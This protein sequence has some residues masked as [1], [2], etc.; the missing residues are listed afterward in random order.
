MYL[1]TKEN[2]QYKWTSYQTIHCGIVM[3]V[4]EL[5]IAVYLAMRVTE[6]YIAVYLA[7]RAAFASA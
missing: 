1:P 3:R 4:T 5:Y 2:I 6:L 7:M